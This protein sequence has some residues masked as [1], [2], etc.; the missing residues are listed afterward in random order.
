MTLMQAFVNL[1]ENRQQVCR[2]LV[3][4]NIL[5]FNIPVNSFSPFLIPSFLILFP[6]P[7]F[8]SFSQQK[9]VA[10]ILIFQVLNLF[11]LHKMVILQDDGCSELDR[12]LGN[13]LTNKLHFIGL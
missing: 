11:F 4:F 1:C 10:R 9:E 2:E 12:R 13:I 6:H 3:T 7:T 8:L 5:M